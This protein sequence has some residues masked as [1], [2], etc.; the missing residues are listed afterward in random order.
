MSTAKRLTI[1]AILVLGVPYTLIYLFEISGAAVVG[2]VFAI[3]FSLAV[4][5]AFLIYQIFLARAANTEQALNGNVSP[6]ALRKFD[7]LFRALLFCFL[8]GLIFIE[9]IPFSKDAYELVFRDE[10]YIVEGKR[11]GERGNILLDKIVASDGRLYTYPYSLE[12]LHSSATYVFVALPRSR[13]VLS[14]AEEKYPRP[15]PKS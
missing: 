7:L 8:L 6:K 15:A 1:V 3:A 2:K 14:T 13:L 11:Y 4:A 9:V 10:R 5:V 12:R